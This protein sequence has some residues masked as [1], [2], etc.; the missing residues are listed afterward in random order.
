MSKDIFREGLKP[1]LPEESLDTIAEW[2]SDLDL[3]LTLWEHRESK[4]GDFR[5]PRN[6]LEPGRISVNKSLNKYA[7]L[8]TIVHEISH[9]VV[10]YRWGRSVKPHGR[11][12]KDDYRNRMMF[13][14]LNNIFPT[15]IRMALMPTLINPSASTA[16][17]GELM[18]VLR[19]YDE[20]KNKDNRVTIDELS[21]GDRF[22]AHNG[23]VFTLGKKIRTNYYCYDENNGDTYRVSGQALVTKL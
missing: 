16:R 23:K 2:L 19:R 6:P 13:F 10:Y 8:I 17:E 3:H 15:D 18:K 12:W 5:A 20:G 22:L 14:A 11:E 7:F 9:A 1:Y 21:E 4:F